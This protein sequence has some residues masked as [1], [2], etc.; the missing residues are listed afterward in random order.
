MS[1]ANEHLKK[2]TKFLVFLKSQ[3]ELLFFQRFVINKV[4][5]AS[6]TDLKGQ[7]LRAQH[8]PAKF[9]WNCQCG[10][11]LYQSCQGNLVTAQS[12]KEAD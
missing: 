3:Y 6:G 9:S 5:E 1:K 8:W 11:I 2:Y 4:L 7:S 10:V 12:S